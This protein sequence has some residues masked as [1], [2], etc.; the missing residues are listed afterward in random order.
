MFGYE[1]Y[2]RVVRVVTQDCFINASVPT[3]GILTTT[4]TTQESLHL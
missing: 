4:T 1:T 3:S 2:A